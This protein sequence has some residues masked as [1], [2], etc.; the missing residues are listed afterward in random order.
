[1][2]NEILYI[3]MHMKYRS[4]FISDTHI[5]SRNCNITKL[6][7]FLKDADSEYIYIVGDFI[8]GWELK[9]KWYWNP[10]YNTLIQKL[11]RKSRKGTKIYITY[12]NHDDF[13]GGFENCELGNIY[14]CRQHIHTTIDNKQYLILHGDQF[15][16]IVKY[17]K[18]LQ[19]I[20]SHLYNVI[21][22]INSVVNK[23]LRKTGRTY[24]FAK[25]IKSSTKSAVNFVSKFEECVITA[26]QQNNCVGVVCGHVHTHADKYLNEIHYINTG[27]WQENEFTVAVETLDGK[28]KLIHI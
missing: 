13:L 25:A 24:S 28:V 18:W 9:N 16:G 14:V 17:A 12:G 6:L 8:D 20:G 26:A 19:H 21:I 7:D 22:D 5:G 3:Y 1:M 11:L 15:D 27:S 4:I 2:F 23:M 10:E